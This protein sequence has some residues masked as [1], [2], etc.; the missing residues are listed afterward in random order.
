MKKHT[1]PI[2]YLDHSATTEPYPEVIVLS[3]LFRVT[4]P[5]FLF[6]NRN[7]DGGMPPRR[8][9]PR[10]EPPCQEEETREYL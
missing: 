1:P 4:K 3:I 9:V 10:Q 2:I 8:E 7:K 5:V 6:I